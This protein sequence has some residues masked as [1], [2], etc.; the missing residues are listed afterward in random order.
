M[1]L[2]ATPLPGVFRIELDPV[3]DDRGSFLRTVCRDFLHASGLVT[4]FPQCN[5]VRNRRRG[6]LRGLHFQTP[7]H[8][9]AKLVHC[10]SG[11]VFD[12]VADLRRGSPKFGAAFAWELRAERPEVLYVP[13]G[14]AHGYQTLADDTLVY[15]HM[16]HRYVPAAEGRVRYDDPRLGITWPVPAPILSSK[17]RDAPPYAW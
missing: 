10:L 5:L 12:V 7:P 14:C 17:D 2:H 16:S 4:D 9:E 1:R 15:Y 8:A 11:A 13:E 3:A 6:V